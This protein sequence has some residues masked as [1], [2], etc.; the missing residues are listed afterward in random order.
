MSES[1]SWL[2]ISV[3]PDTLS[4]GIMCRHCLWRLVIIPDDSWHLINCELHNKTQDCMFCSWH[5]T[6]T[7]TYMEE[8]GYTHTLFVYPVHFPGCTSP[9]VSPQYLSSGALTVSSM[10]K[11]RSKEA[12]PLI[13]VPESNILG[14]P[15][16]GRGRYSSLLMLQSTARCGVWLKTKQ[17]L[18]AGRRANRVLLIGQTARDWPVAVYFLRAKQRHL[19]NLW[20]TDPVSP[21]FLSPLHTPFLNPDNKVSQSDESLSFFLLLCSVCNLWGLIGA[22]LSEVLSDPP[23]VTAK[24]SLTSDCS[25]L[26]LVLLID[27]SHASQ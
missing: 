14:D 18:S 6:A 27:F 17:H 22:L 10:A 2:S 13:N 7:C 19:T 21:L 23:G 4:R 12:A 11:M 15:K 24:R 25:Q 8:M 3:Q 26:L 9:P 5:Y 20:C 1:I 16:A